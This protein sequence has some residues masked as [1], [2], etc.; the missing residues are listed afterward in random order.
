MADAT[1]PLPTKSP[2]SRSHARA[3]PKN[4]GTW[5]SE[6]HF[7]AIL[8]FLLYTAVSVYFIFDL[9][10][11]AGDAASRV[12][13][14]YYVLFSRNPHLGAIGMIWNPLP[15]LLELPIVALHP[16]F[17]A[18]VSR[19][20]AGNVVTSVFGAIGV[21]HLNHIIRGFA[22]PKWVRITGTLVYAL[23][24]FIVL[25]G[26]N[27]M[28]DLLWV[29]CMLGSYDG[30]LDYLQQGSLR[31]L[32][33]GGFWLALGF[34]MRYEAVPFGAFVI[35]ALI[36][37]QW[38]KTQAAQWQ[39]SAILLGS[40]IVF[41]GGLWLYFNWLIMKRPLYFLNSSY[42]N[43]AQTAT[44]SG[45]NGALARAYHHPLASFLYVAH[46]GFLYWPI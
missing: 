23:N 20:I 18:V 24:P 22:V 5:L 31:R 11:Y 4:A 3:I 46:F 27:G 1:A 7:L 45:V 21:Y 33:M 39:G 32:M 9:H 15:S 19:G 34:G 35:V 28:T 2:H 38:G 29:T 12:G 25:Y 41:V 42:G 26:A 36:V 40:P 16:W 14:A 8:A 37:T 13:N 44:G 17:P 10:Y 6:G 43:L 30:I